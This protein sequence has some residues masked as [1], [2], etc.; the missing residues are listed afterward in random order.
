M[1]FQS[2]R[3]GI[4]IAIDALRSNKVRAFL[5]ILG[6]SIGVMTVMAMAAIVVGVQRGITED[7]AA[8]G[9]EN[10]AVARFDPTALQIVSHGPPWGDNPQLELKEAEALRKL[11][12][13]QSVTPFV[14]GG[15]QLRHRDRELS[16][17]SM[18]GVGA[19]WTDYIAGDVLAGRVLLADDLA[20]SANVVVVS[21]QVQENLFDGRNPVGERIRISGT[22]FE[23]VGV[24]KRKPNLLQGGGSGQQV[25]IPITAVLKSLNADRDL[26]E[27]W[28]VPAP[29]YTQQ[30]AMDQVTATMRGLRRLGPAEENNFALVRQ[31]AV[32]DMING[33]LGM[34]TTVMMVLASIG[35][36]VGGVGVV[37]IMMISVTE[38]TREIGVRKALGATRREIL[39]QFL[40]EAVTVTVIG[41]VVGMV[42]GAGLALLVSAATP[43]PAAVPLWSVVAA[44]ATS[45]VTGILF[46]LYPANKAARLDPVEA[47]RYE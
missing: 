24:Y 1:D 22:Q 37:G 7:L 32:A 28:V 16:S 3:E 30:Q 14:S 46:G 36:M 44:L 38:R 6:V 8:I 17:V 13:V 35:L 39:W 43:I 25:Y 47:L 45:A 31:E 34:L 33:I 15:A 42:M 26:M 20:R 29:G 19:E 18:L 9:P 10:F 23:V 11:P 4:Q 41:G 12:A 21:D 27:A 2:T 40:V 5:T